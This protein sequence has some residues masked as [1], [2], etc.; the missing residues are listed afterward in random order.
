VDLEEQLTTL[1]QEYQIVYDKRQ[2]YAAR[3][4]TIRLQRRMNER[5]GFKGQEN[6]AK[7]MSRMDNRLNEYELE[8]EALRQVRS[9]NSQ[10]NQTNNYFSASKNLEVE[11]QLEQLKKRLNKEG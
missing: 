5:L 1:K 4:E 11:Q 6:T 7:M 9:Q 10:Y 3:M 8:N 2:Y